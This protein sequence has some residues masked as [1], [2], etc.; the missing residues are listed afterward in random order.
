MM[1]SQINSIYDPLGLAGPFT[2]RA[3]IMKRKQWVRG[4]ESLDW[5]NPV[6]DECRADWNAFFSDLFGMNNIKLAT[7]YW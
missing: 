4:P 7:Q 2:V 5:D 1:V 6:S 3:K